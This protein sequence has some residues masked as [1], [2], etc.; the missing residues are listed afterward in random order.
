VITIPIEEFSA[1]QGYY[2]LN[3]LSYLSRGR[4]NIMYHENKY[5]IYS[6]NAT[7]VKFSDITGLI[8]IQMELLQLILFRDICFIIFV[9]LISL[10]FVKSSLKQL[11]KLTQFTRH[12][13]FENLST[14]IHLKGHKHDE[15]TVIAEA[16]NTSLQKIN[17][18]ILSLKDFIS[19]ASHELKTPLMMI[20]SEIDIALKTEHHENHLLNIKQYIKRLSDLLDTLSLITRLESEKQWELKNI[21][22]QMLIQEVVHEIHKQYPKRQIVITTEKDLMIG[23]HPTLLKIIIKNLVENACNYAGEKATIT[24]EATATSLSIHDT[25]KGIA[26]EYHKK[27]F[28]RFRQLKKKEDK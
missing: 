19:N 14:A 8:Y 15:I 21:I 12:L 3:I 7:T 1:E 28:E 13:D 10:Y 5:F 24:I 26:P 6:V 27:I 22:P 17:T 11:K 18:Q 16:L 4:V 25:G 9:Y 2:P 23:A 20:H